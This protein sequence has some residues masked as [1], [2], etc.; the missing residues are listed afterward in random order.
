MQISPIFET[1][2]GLFEK[3]LSPMIYFLLDLLK[4]KH[5]TEFML[6]P[7]SFKR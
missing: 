1:S 7:I 4:S 5:G 6:M 2:T 3:A